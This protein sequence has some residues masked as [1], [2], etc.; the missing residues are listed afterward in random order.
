LNLTGNIFNTLGN[1]KAIG[2]DLV[3]FTGPGGCGK[4]GQSPLPVSTGG[5][6]LEIRDVVVGGKQ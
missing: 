5:P 4:G 3:L 1:I 2:N 6:H